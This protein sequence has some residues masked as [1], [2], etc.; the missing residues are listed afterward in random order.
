MVILI[1]QMRHLTLSGV[2]VLACEDP[3]TGRKAE[4][5][6]QAAQPHI[7][8]SSPDTRVPLTEA[9]GTVELWPV[10]SEARVA[11]EQDF[12]A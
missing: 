12:G 9:V 3:A 11:T 1:L 2:R 7:P 5:R 10:T 6:T 8:K 4:I